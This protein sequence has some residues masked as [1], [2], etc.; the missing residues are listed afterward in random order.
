MT[1]PDVTVERWAALEDLPSGVLAGDL[2]TDEVEAWIDVASWVLFNLSGRRYPGEREQ[3]IRPVRRPT[4]G[5]V[6]ATFDGSSWSATGI[7]QRWLRRWASTPGPGVSEVALPNY[8]VTQVVEVLVDGAVIPANLYRVDDWRTLVYL[9]DPDDPSDIGSW[10]V[11]QDLDAASTEPGTWEVTYQWG[12]SPP[13]AGRR[14]AAALAAE[15]CRAVDESLGECR[16]PSRAT[17]I[18]RQGVTTS[19]VDPLTVFDSGYTGVPIVDQFLSAERVG[20][21]TRRASLID[22]ARVHHTRARVTDTAVP[23]S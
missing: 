13:L 1:Q 23:G 7:A 10:P 6:P 15:F 18:T 22:P 16:L 20:R 14:A 8:P 11:C 12:T 2:T 17:S 3:T 4:G 9:P 5:Y 21:R 19:L